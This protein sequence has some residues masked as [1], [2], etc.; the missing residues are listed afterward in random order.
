MTLVMERDGARLFPQEIHRCD[1][2]SQLMG[3]R[4]QRV[5]HDHTI[6]V[7]EFDVNKREPAAGRCWKG[8]PVKALEDERAVPV[9]RSKLTRI[10][11][12]FRA[13]V[14]RGNGHS[15]D[16]RLASDKGWLD[17]A[18]HGNCQSVGALQL[19]VETQASDHSIPSNCGQQRI[20]EFGTGASESDLSLAKLSCIVSPLCRGGCHGGCAVAGLKPQPKATSMACDNNLGAVAWPWWCSA[21]T[22][23]LVHR[24]RPLSVFVRAGAGGVPSSECL[25]GSK[26]GVIRCPRKPLDQRPETSR[27]SRIPDTGKASGLAR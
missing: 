3:L 9:E 13:H 6:D 18:V 7:K 10:V 23:D 1:V 12:R 25:L 20:N 11:Y 8:S 5:L 27:E 16:R 21:V 4:L 14:L 17:L 24:P 26:A 22:A 15:H 19:P 2:D